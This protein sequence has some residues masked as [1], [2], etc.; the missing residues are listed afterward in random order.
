M[1]M[2]AGE[3]EETALKLDGTHGT[4]EQKGATKEV[5]THIPLPRTRFV[6]E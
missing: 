4:T 6:N 5:T 2:L 3:R 1:F